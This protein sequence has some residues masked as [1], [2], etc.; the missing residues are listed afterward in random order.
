MSLIRYEIV[1]KSYVEKWVYEAKHKEFYEYNKKQILKELSNW[2]GEGSLDFYI[3][4]FLGKG[5]YRVAGF[6]GFK[7]DYYSCKNK[8]IEYFKVKNSLL[9]DNH[10]LKYGSSTIVFNAGDKIKYNE[11]E[12]T[13]EYI[14]HKEDGTIQYFVDYCIY[15]DADLEKSR[16]EAIEIWMEEEFG[17]KRFSDLT[18]E[19]NERDSL[20]E[21]FDVIN[22]YY[23]KEIS[24]NQMYHKLIMKQEID[25]KTKNQSREED[26]KNSLKENKVYFWGAVTI[27]AVLTIGLIFSLMLGGN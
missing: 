22:S 23:E 14:V 12:L 19:E 24:Y 6:Y 17:E 9:S 4:S 13:I 15:L 20:I 1:C 2:T 10:I 5:H 11:E 16:Q 3:G 18:E 25:V 21:F 26:D 7:W 27:I 8:K